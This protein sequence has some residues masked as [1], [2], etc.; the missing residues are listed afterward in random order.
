MFQHGLKL[1]KKSEQSKV[2]TPKP[3]TSTT[4][5]TS[6]N[7]FLTTMKPP[8]SSIMSKFQSSTFDIE[9][10][11]D[12]QGPGMFAF[13][14]GN[15]S[16]ENIPKTSTFV[17]SEDSNSLICTQ[18]PSSLRGRTFRTSFNSSRKSISPVSERTTTDKMTDFSFINDNANDSAEF[19]NLQKGERPTSQNVASFEL[20]NKDVGSERNESKIKESSVV[21]KTIGKSNAA[22]SSTPQTQSKDLKSTT[23]KRK[24]KRLRSSEEIEDEDTSTQEI[25]VG[26]RPD[27][28]RTLNFKK[29]IV[30][31]HATKSH[32]LQPYIAKY[33]YKEVFV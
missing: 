15:H 9:P 14:T 2:D 20:T 32:I 26:W 27:S 11:E 1:I 4:K 6:P 17:S 21:A 25:A 28:V 33:G 10:T 12:N 19:H 7:G 30:L 29:E 23:P 18:N 3:A 5:S 22:I 16:P 24:L 13:A 31:W 8:F